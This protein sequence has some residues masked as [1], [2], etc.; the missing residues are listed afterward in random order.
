MFLT[1]T[2][3]LWWRNQVED[4]VAGRT[5]EKIENWEEMKA[6]LKAQFGP[7]NQAWITRN[8]LLALKHTGKIQAYIKEFTGLMLEIKDMWK[9]NTTFPLH[10][11][12]TT[13]GAK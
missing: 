9:K 3:K 13:M 6:S 2:A 11:W 8:Q 7:G 1:G 4:L 12:S 10:E 5:I